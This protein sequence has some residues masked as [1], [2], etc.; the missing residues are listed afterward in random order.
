M[1]MTRSRFVSPLLFTAVLMGGCTEPSSEEGDGGDTND[2]SDSGAESTDTGGADSTGE[3]LPAPSLP[4]VDAAVF[5]GGPIDNRY[6]PLS[7][8]ATWRYET[9]TDEGVE[10][11]VIEVLAETREIQGVTA[12]VVRDTASL[13]GMVIEDTHDWFAQDAEGNVWYLGEETCEFEM[14][15]CVDTV[16]SWEWGVDGAL[17]GIIMK[18]DPTVDGE[19]YYTEYYM[20]EAEDAAE[21][22]EVGVS[23]T[24]PAGSFEGC[25]VTHETSTLDPMLDELKTYCPDVGNVLVEETQANEELVEYMIP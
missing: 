17:P 9:Q 3:P 25:I 22:V 1:T 5:D 18:A 16:G 7:V 23:V 24:V 14:G 10:E 2:V 4:D 21:V 12:V 19:R 8:G 6:L 11:V 15:E 20:G 13:D